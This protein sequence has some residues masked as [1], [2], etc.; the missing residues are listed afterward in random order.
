MT[1]PSRADRAPANEESSEATL[2]VPER[3]ARRTK[4]TWRGKPVMTPEQKKAAKAANQKRRKDNKDSVSAQ[5]R[6]DAS[7]AVAHAVFE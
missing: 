5:A 2:E 7:K 4:T 3:Q 1:A 6:R